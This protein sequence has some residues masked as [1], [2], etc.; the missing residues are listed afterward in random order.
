[1]IDCPCY[2]LPGYSAIHLPDAQSFTDF[3][4]LRV[5]NKYSRLNG[6]RLLVYI[7]HFRKENDEHDIRSGSRPV[8]SVRW[9]RRHR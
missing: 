5:G 2:Q 1:M 7:S 9:K 3:A 6:F 8:V 4:N